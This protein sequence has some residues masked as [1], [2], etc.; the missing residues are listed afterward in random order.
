MTT[1]AA[2]FLAPCSN[3]DAQEHLERTVI[4]RV[5]RD[6]YGSLTS[7]DF[8]NL[9]GIWGVKEGNKPIW[10]SLSS[11]DFLLFYTGEGEYT[12]AAEVLATEVNEELATELWP[13]FDDTWEYIIYLASSLEVSIPS[14]EL[15]DRAGYAQEYVLGFQ[16]L[17]EQGLTSI[18]ADYGDVE[19]YLYAHSDAD[20]PSGPGEIE[21]EIE[22]PDT[23]PLR[24]GEYTDTALFSDIARQLETNKQVVFYGPPGTGKT[25]I[26][27]NFARWWLHQD[28]DNPSEAQLRSVTFHPSFTYEDF[29]E[30]LS[31]TATNDGVEYK[32]EPGVFRR[33]CTTAETALEQWRANGEDGT[34]PRYILIVDEINRGNLSQIF[35]ET[36]TLLESDKRGTVTS[37]LAHSGRSFSVP[38]NVY[39]IGT[40]NTADRSIAL[41]DAALRRRFRFIDFPPNPMVLEAHFD[42]DNREAVIE[43]AQSRP[44][45]LEGLQALSI[46]AVEQINAAIIDI[47]DLGKG[48]QIGHSYLMV[49]PAS[50]QSL[51]DAWRYEIL[52]LLEEYFFG[53]FDRIRSDVFGGAG[54]ALVKWDTEQIRDFDAADLRGSLRS[55]VEFEG[56]E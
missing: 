12:L 50:E 25:Y 23:G 17:N 32:I 31:A 16:P 15:H 21:I 56:G 54:D 27:Q 41:V 2:V 36:I 24:D 33:L 5:S 46:L 7:V 1:D 35:G 49:N 10:E 19:S 37:E 55:R 48:K 26:A 53:Q 40:M 13:G 20:G 45:T 38:E 39:L 14:R 9:V 8:G 42:F 34:M 47:P 44:N 18:R 22:A 4:E 30:G 6:T 11:G 43:A 52:P 29:I 28:S 3:S 51:V